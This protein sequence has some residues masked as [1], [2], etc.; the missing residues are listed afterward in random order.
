MYRLTKKAA[1]QRQKLSAMRIG[2]ERARMARP[3]EER[4]PELP[5]LRRR[6][7][8]EDFDFGPASMSSNCI[9]RRVEIAV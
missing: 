8:I 9:G 3:A 2:Q 1:A 6:I 4:A 5:E 7:V